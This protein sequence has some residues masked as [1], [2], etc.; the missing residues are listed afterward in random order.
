MASQSDFE[1]CYR[2][3]QTTLH[4][5]AYMRMAKVLLALR[6]I[7]DAGIALEEKR[8]LDYGF[9]AGTF[10]RYCPRS[11]SLAGVEIDPENVKAVAEMLRARGYT[12]LALERLDVEEWQ[13]HP[14]LAKQYDLVLC[15]HVLEHAPDAIILLK[16][17]KQCVQPAG[18]IVT[19]LPVN[20]TV[21]DPHHVHVVDRGLIEDWAEQAGL[22]ISN[23]IEDDPWFYWAQFLRAGDERWKRMFGQA[24]S[25]GVGVAA[26]I[27]GHRAWWRLSRLFAAVTRS[28]PRQAAFLLRPKSGLAREKP[29]ER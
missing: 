23:Y 20:E 7:D 13:Q 17:L 4:H 2:D 11:A 16:R 25:L 21:P 29:L 22:Q 15:S 26:T 24:C 10:F 1:H 9:G 27:L 3:R 12:R 14:L 6:I 8:I 18:A 28:K 5:M 19:L